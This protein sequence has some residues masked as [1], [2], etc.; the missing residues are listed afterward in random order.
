[1]MQK[2]E[3]V[4]ALILKLHEVNETLFD[5]FYKLCG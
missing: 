1:M 5:N 2:L 3:I 4:S